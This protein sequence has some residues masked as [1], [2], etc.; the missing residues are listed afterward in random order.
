MSLNYAEIGLN[1]FNRL[2]SIWASSTSSSYSEFSKLGRIEPITLIDSSLQHSESLE[3]IL[4]SLQSVFAAYFLQAVSFSMNIGKVNVRKELDRLN[5]NRNPLDSAVD[6][7]SNSIN[8]LNY[9]DKLPDFKKLNTS[10]EA[11]P[12]DI[13][14][15]RDA[16]KGIHEDSNL[17][18]G[19]VFE[20]NLSDGK[21]SAPVLV[22]IR[23]LTYIIESS[24]L[25][26]TMSID[27]QRDITFAERLHLFKSKVISITDLITCNDLV[28]EYR[29]GLMKDKSG[30]LDEIISRNDKNKLSGILSMNPSIGTASN[31]AIISKDTITQLE[32]KTH[33]KIDNANYRKKI[34]DK[35]SLMILCVVDQDL[36][37]IIMYVRGIVIPT[38]LSIKSMKNASKGSGP[39]VS[40]ILKSLLEGRPP[41]F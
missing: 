34:F 41:I 24:T 4:L 3:P 30:I 37:Q 11:S 32:K 9:K 5:P 39:D 31:I 35:T 19:K 1:F 2:S 27:D 33:S 12:T 14:F 28:D 7:L 40:S 22:S 18:L 17:A 13:H 6:S 10:L 20:I 26:S 8:L 25:V 16:V 38:K 15:G 23:L 21:H 36:E 29:S